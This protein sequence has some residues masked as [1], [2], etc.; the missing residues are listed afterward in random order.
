METITKSQTITLDDG[1]PLALMQTFRLRK[2]GQPYSNPS[3]T[4]AY[5]GSERLKQCTKC[6]EWKDFE[7]FRTYSKNYDGKF[8]HCKTCET[9]YFVK[10]DRSDKG[11]ERFTRRAWLESGVIKADPAYYAYVRDYFDGACALTGAT[12]EP[13][14]FDHALPLAWGCVGNELGNLLP[15]TVTM[16]KI[17]RTRNILEVVEGL[18]AEQQHHFYTNV[19]PWL[20]GENDMHVDEYTELIKFMEEHKI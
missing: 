11:R 7:R 14:V 9:K 2:D 20:A 18:T 15:M 3:K 4:V 8:S 10:Y 12:D 1:R 6:G 16:N 13:I 19:L 17:K 5:S